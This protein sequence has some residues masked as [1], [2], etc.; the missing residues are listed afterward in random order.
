[1]ECVCREKLLINH[2][3]ALINTQDDC[4]TPAPYLQGF[5]IFRGR[6]G[7]DACDLICN[8]PEKGGGRVEEQPRVAPVEVE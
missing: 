1:M 8:N 3:V 2:L 6:D 4:L 7:D 5:A